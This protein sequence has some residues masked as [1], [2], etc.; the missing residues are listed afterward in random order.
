MTDFAVI[1]CVSFDHRASP[2]GLLKF[3]KCILACPFVETAIEVTGSFDLILH[4]RATTFAEYNEQ[5]GRIGPQL[6]QFVSRIETNFVCK[7]VETNKTEHILWVPCRDGRKR[8]DANMIDKVVADGD[9]MRLYIGPWNCL[10]HETLGRLTKSLDRD[11]FLRLHRSAVVRIDF[12]ERLIHREHFWEARL[13]DGTSQ[14]VAKS[15]VAE[16][17][18]LISNHSATIEDKS[19][20]A[21]SS[22]PA[23]EQI[24]EMKMPVTR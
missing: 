11:R 14:R 16:V 13:S 19:S 3:K 17:V 18:Q 7:K 24:N 21:D 22:V 1:V 2:A 5:M 15:H 20:K 10:L 4:G 23:V 9:Y 12:I 8:I 6:A